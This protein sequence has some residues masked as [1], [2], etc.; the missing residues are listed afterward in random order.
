MPSPRRNKTRKVPHDRDCAS[1][2]IVLPWAPTASR[3]Q[4]PGT[5][6]VGAS[7]PMRSRKA[8]AFR[9]CVVAVIIT[10]NVKAP[11]HVTIW[12]QLRKMKAWQALRQC[13]GPCACVWLGAEQGEVP[14]CWSVFNLGLKLPSEQS[15]CR[16]DEP[17]CLLAF[18]LFCPVYSGFRSLKTEEEGEQ[19]S[20]KSVL[21]RMPGSSGL[22]WCP[23]VKKMQM[24]VLSPGGLLVAAAD[25]RTHQPCQHAGGGLYR[26]PR[27]ST[28]WTNPNRWGRVRGWRGAVCVTWERTLWSD[29]HLDV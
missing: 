5:V 26:S 23:A 10:V 4:K 3:C 7:K 22:E 2:P 6:I 29:L 24:S 14:W 15:V 1:K 18:V 9:F 8:K 19:S 25:Q 12:G 20:N 28:E 27:F 16:P 13:W 17:K 11:D 21:Q